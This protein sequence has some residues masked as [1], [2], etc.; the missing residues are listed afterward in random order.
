MTTQ[1][2]LQ[3]SKDVFTHH[4]A[5]APVIMY[6]HGILSMLGALKTGE[7][8]NDTAYIE[9]IVKMLEKFPDEIPHRQYNFPSYFIGG[10]A[11][12][13][14][15]FKG[16]MTDDRTKALVRQYAEEFMT[17]PRDRDGVLK[18]P[19]LTTRE[20]IWIDVATA[21]TPFL[22]YAG[23]TFHEPA[24]IDEA[25]YQT[26]KM[27]DIFLDP[28]NGLLHQVR[29]K[30][31][32][33]VITEDHWGRGNG[34]GYFPLAELVQYLPKEHPQRGRVEDY[35]GRHAYALL[36]YQTEHGV[37]CQELTDLNSYEEASGTGLILYGYGVG[38]RMG[39][40]H[41]IAFREPYE[42][43][44]AGMCKQFIMDDLRIKNVCPGCCAPGR[45]R[46]MGTI[47]AYTQLMPVIDDQHGFGPIQLAL[48]EAALH[49]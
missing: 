46:L 13:Y 3:L 43:G 45:G 42:E 34:W 32:Q 44:L 24:W 19:D 18:L 49:T 35:F 15:L 9:K 48:A 29:G 2:K 10:N 8:A 27:Y 41:E 26:L 17:A 12:A 40:L 7:I 38:L 11:R 20:L 36:K 21:V 16:Y 1:E 4:E 47:R 23:L 33:G 28:A 22:L 6:Y 39:L 31:A 5:V 30:V 25:V 37:W 14:A